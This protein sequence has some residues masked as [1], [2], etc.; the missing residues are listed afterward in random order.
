MLA[1]LTAGTLTLA[2]SLNLL[3][4]EKGRSVTVEQRF[5][6]SGLGHSQVSSDADHVSGPSPQ[7]G[8][9]RVLPGECGHYVAVRRM[10]HG[11]R[12]LTS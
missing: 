2:L 3:I 6:Q 5:F 12:P 4:S 8:R 11:L 7:P 1:K 10:D 9:S